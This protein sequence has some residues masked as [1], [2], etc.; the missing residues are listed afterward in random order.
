MERRPGNLT[1]STLLLAT[2]LLA[3]SGI[4]LA[5][6]TV[7]TATA[8]SATTAS[9]RAESRTEFQNRSLNDDTWINEIGTLLYSDQ[10]G[11]GYFSSLS[12]SIDADSR[13]TQIEVYLIVDIIDETGRVE[14][15]HTT[16]PFYVYGRSFTDEYRIDIDLLQNF[17]PG[18]YDLEIFLVDAFRD[19]IIDQVDARDFKNLRSLP[20]ESEDNQTGNRPV[21]NR[22]SNDSNNNIRTSEHAGSFG[23]LFLLTLL[24][25]CLARKFRFNARR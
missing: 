9:T 15:L 1:T 12:L 16:Y 23:M 7:S 13:F 3:M 6:D 5:D 22:P 11:D 25:S 18:V 4:T 8:A 20:L 24:A 21:G 10:D 17:F 14:N 2:S 19:R